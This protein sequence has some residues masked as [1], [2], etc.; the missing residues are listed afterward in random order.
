MPAIP[1]PVYALV[2]PDQTFSHW[3]PSVRQ[4]AVAVVLLALMNAVSAYVGAGPVAETAAVGLLGT[5]LLVTLVWWVG[6]AAVFALFVTPGQR[7]DFRALLAIAGWGLLPAAIRYV[8]R[9]IIVTQA[10]ES[11][12]ASHP[13]K[14]LHPTARPLAGSTDML[15]FGGVIA[16]T[17][18]WQVMIYMYALA[19]AERVSLRRAA[20]VAGGLAVISSPFTL[21]GVESPPTTDIMHS[22]FLIVIG[23]LCVAKPSMITRL[24]EN[25]DAGSTLRMSEIEPPVWS[26][27]GTRALGTG[28]LAGAIWLLSG[29]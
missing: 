7:S 15:L 10:A 12:I 16:V 5:T 13:I 2:R 24:R 4:A 19:A 21:G 28:M 14:V 17:L 8:V 27:W 1:Q 25:V 3:R 6:T 23:G 18:L 22:L 20:V 29:P 9:P 11:W 26:V